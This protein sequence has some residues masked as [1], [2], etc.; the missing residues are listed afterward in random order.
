MAPKFIE[1]HQKE[2]TETINEK[3]MDVANDFLSKKTLNDLLALIS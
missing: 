2:L 3:V 1:T